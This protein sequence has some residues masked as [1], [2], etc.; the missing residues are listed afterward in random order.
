MYDTAAAV[1][2]VL[3]AG[4]SARS[5]HAVMYFCDTISIIMILYFSSSS[6]QNTE[7]NSDWLE[8]KCYCRWRRQVTERETKKGNTERQARD[9]SRREKSPFFCAYWYGTACCCSCRMYGTRYCM[10]DGAVLF[11]I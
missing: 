2:F 3:M 8:V 1:L 7:E 9:R 10:Y 6:T 4:V 5:S 11:E